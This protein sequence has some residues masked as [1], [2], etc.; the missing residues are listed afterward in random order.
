MLQSFNLSFV[1]IFVA[2]DIIGVLPMFLSMTR[3]LSHSKRNEIVNK[4]MFVALMVALIFTFVGPNM[5]VYLGITLNDFR[6]AG[7]VVLLLVSLADLVSGPEPVS[8][9]SGST[10]VVPLAVPLIT[11]P[12]VLTTVV[13]QADRA[14]YLITIS[15][16]LANYLLAWYLLY[17]SE[18][19]TRWVG[20]DGTVII[21]KIAALLL[22][23]ISV[24]MIRSG[25]FSAISVFRKG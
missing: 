6:I 5:F 12:G 7:G 23:A 11:G 22:A 3:H 24:A 17:R 2:L 14:G 8:R 19:V 9:A 16:L 21:S 1:S 15:S 20:K 13:L 18:M 25:V 10:G 4:S